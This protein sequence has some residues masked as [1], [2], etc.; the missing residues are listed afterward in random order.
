MT[1]NKNIKILLNYVIGPLVF[2][3]LAWSIYRQ[4]LRQHSWQASLNHTWR[5]LA[6][7]EAWKLVLTILL[8]F[9]NWG[10]EARKWQVV[11]KRIQHLSFFQ[12]CKAVFTGTTL[13][14]F[15]PNRI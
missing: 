2:C 3:L 10:L 12:S 1:L 11:I 9:V 13:A 14:F 7:G 8:M 6:G 5:A 4:L 15:T